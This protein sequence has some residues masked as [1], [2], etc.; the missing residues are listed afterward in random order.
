[1][2]FLARQSIFIATWK[3][4]AQ[5]HRR[6]SGLQFGPNGKQVFR[7]TWVPRAKLRTVKTSMSNVDLRGNTLRQ[8]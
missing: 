3:T 8:N 1:M 5:N 4:G 2:A 7:T 6:H